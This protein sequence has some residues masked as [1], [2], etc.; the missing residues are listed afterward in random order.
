MFGDC[1]RLLPQVLAEDVDAD[2]KHPTRNDERQPVNKPAA[3][4]F[5]AADA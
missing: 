3:I 5:T 2:Y 1:W 4:R